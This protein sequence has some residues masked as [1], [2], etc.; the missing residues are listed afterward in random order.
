MVALYPQ[1]RS[2]NKK[3]SFKFK[4]THMH[5]PPASI[6]L[7]SF[8]LHQY[9]SWPPIQRSLASIPI[10]PLILLSVTSPLPNAILRFHTWITFQSKTCA[11]LNTHSHSCNCL[12]LVSAIPNMIFVYFSVGS[13]QSSQSFPSSRPLPQQPSGIPSWAMLTSSWWAMMSHG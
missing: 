3:L 2:I 9:F 1:R 8:F 11:L 7:P 13:L 12:L 4:N 10:L 6:Y 5:P